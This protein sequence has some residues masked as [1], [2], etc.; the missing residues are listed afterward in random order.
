MHY[1]SA[2]SQLYKSSLV[3]NPKANPPSG[4][5]TMA[6]KRFQVGSKVFLKKTGI[7]GIIQENQGSKT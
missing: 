7:P 6:S 4:K 3:L 2:L 5:A 1:C